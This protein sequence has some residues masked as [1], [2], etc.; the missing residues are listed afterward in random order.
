MILSPW[1]QGNTEVRCHA[2]RI[3]KVFQAAVDAFDTADPEAHLKQIWTKVAV[4][5]SH[6]KVQEESFNEMREVFLEELTIVCALNDKQQQAWNVFFDV[7]YA[8][9]FAKLEEIYQK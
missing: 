6:H 7:A 5:H 9:V 4:T 3:M 2:A 1:F 8:I